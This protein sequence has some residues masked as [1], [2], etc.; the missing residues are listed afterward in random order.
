MTVVIAVT[1]RDGIEATLEWEK[2]GVLWARVYE[3]CGGEWH[4]T[5]ESRPFHPSDEDKAK[6]AY[7]R[8]VKRYITESKEVGWKAVRNYT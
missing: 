1:K 3:N 2:P 8:F 5:H 4:Q 7:K 6:A